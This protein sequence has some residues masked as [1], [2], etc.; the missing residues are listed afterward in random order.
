MELPR[1]KPLW[2]KYHE[3][4]LEIVV[5][6]STQAREGALKFIAEQSLS[7]HFIEDTKSEGS[8]IA[9]VTDDYRVTAFPT[10][11]II[12]RNGKVQFYHLGFEAGDETKIE[13]EILE[14]LE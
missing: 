9:D 4:G 3:K 6:E 12:D 2:E 7:Y 5:I 14:L 13:K 1:L 8:T 11:F 10:S